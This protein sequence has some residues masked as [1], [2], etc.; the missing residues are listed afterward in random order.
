MALKNVQTT[1]QEVAV[2]KSRLAKQDAELYELRQQLRRA[3]N[4]SGGAPAQLPLQSLLTHPC[5]DSRAR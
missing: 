5:G 2:L 3:I 4:H 1:E